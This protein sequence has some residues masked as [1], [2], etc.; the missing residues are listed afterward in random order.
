M[1]AS[2]ANRDPSSRIAA[3][4]KRVPYTRSWKPVQ[5][6]T[7]SRPDNTTDLDIRQMICQVHAVVYPV[8]EFYQQCAQRSTHHTAPR[9][10]ALTI[11]CV[12]CRVV[13]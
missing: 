8:C 10:V 1:G 3:S 5:G 12:S 13:R 7:H 6:L 4:Q 2:L 9:L 11:M